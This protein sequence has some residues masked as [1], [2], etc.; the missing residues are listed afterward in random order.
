MNIPVTETSIP[1]IVHR[2]KDTEP[3]IRKLV[4]S[5]VLA[6]DLKKDSPH[7]PINLSERQLE[8]ICRNGFGDREPNVKA[9]A[10]ELI[11]AWLRILGASDFRDEGEQDMTAQIERLLGKFN[12][13]DC[14]VANDMLLGVFREL[15]HIFESV[16]FQGAS[17][18]LSRTQQ[19]NR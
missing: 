7:S 17:A 10:A 15:P 11:E 3:T 9:A 19:T 4:Y 16:K 2:T 8:L 13:V 6:K 1:A 18:L 12:L 14:K 5:H